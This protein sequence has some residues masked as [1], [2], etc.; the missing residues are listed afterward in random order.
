MSIYGFI[1][2][3]SLK[4]N[5]N[6]VVAPLGEL[7]TY[8][9][10]SSIEKSTFTDILKCPG[11]ELVTFRN[12]GL[13]S[14]PVKPPPSQLEADE[15]LKI[16]YWAAQEAL[17]GF[18]TDSEAL[19]LQNFNQKFGAIAA[20]ATVG[21]MVTNGI[22]WLPDWLR[23]QPVTMKDGQKV[24]GEP[25][26]IWFADEPFRRQYSSYDFAIVGPVDNLDDLHGN[27]AAVKELIESRDAVALTEKLA[28]ATGKVPPT[29]IQA[30]VYDWIDKTD[31]EFKVPTAWHVV[32]WGP[33]GNNPDVIRDE[34]VDWI[35]AN[36]KFP[37]AEWEKILP[38][39]F[40][41]TEYIFVPSWDQYAIP[42]QTLEAGLY[43]PLVN[44]QKG[45]EL[46]KK[47]APTYEGEHITKYA[48]TASNAYRSLGFV[49][50][51][52]KRNR[53]GI[54][55]FYEKFKDY[56]ALPTTHVDFNRISPRTQAWMMKFAE[57][58]VHAEAMTTESEIPEGFS[59]LTR[60]GVVYCAFS[61]EKIQYLVVTKQ[62]LNPGDVKYVTEAPDLGTWLRVAGGWIETMSA[63]D[64]LAAIKSG[65]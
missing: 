60:N 64:F 26:R 36:S 15:V 34:L 4:D 22:H 6:G 14:N 18:N 12:R 2:V 32:I 19:F 45:M 28:A 16:A 51:G 54:F 57:C 50:C 42:N 44:P 8:A 53:D 10:S 35:L 31:R 56:I 47:G 41:S 48:R 3:D 30:Q 25:V 63:A 38:D 46:M 20:N 7:S 29:I 33:A 55:D 9:L 61:Y 62:G 5:E 24:Y 39:L 13:S 65:S 49:V 37:R 1:R 43:S 58:I 59:R 27:K 21:V 23:Y 11:I 52:G 40:I 17:N